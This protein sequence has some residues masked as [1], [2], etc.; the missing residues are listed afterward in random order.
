MAE[1]EL[2]CV[3]VAALLRHKYASILR[4]MSMRQYMSE[5]LRFLFYCSRYLPSLSTAQ[6][7]KH[8]HCS[9]NNLDKDKLKS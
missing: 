4:V 5:L 1:S 3:R 8:S 7:K 9:G 2:L 6:E